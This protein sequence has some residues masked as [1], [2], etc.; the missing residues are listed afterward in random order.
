M[1]EGVAQNHVNEMEALIGRLPAV[2]RSKIV[3][4]DWGGIEEIHVL[5]SLERTA[6]QVVRDVE[7]ALSA[8]WGIHVDHKRISVAQIRT[9][10]IVKVRQFL[11]VRQVAVD[12]DTVDGKIQA[13]VEIEPVNDDGTVYRGEW[14]GKY[15]PS[16]HTMAVAEA[17]VRALNGVPE[18]SE[19]L[20]LAE[21]RPMEL[22]GRSVVLV[23]LS[24]LN[25]NHREEL[26]MGTAME[27]GDAQGAAAHAVV[28]AVNRW[29]IRL[30]V[31]RSE[32]PLLPFILGRTLTGTDDLPQ[33][34][35]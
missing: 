28:D 14:S 22:G 27:S 7:S 16:H 12:V 15:V 29:M 21:L 3:I 13:S 9:D 8:E 32:D 23:A 4:N 26:L 2:L 24:Y 20:V 34:E 10:D 11:I 31:K 33:G 19:G 5:T 6:K 18:V 17:A 25:P 1:D 35:P 30:D